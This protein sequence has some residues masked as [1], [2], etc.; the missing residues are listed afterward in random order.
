MESH[1]SSVNLPGSIQAVDALLQSG[2]KVNDTLSDGESALV[3]AVA[4]AHWEL[5]DLGDELLLGSLVGGD[6]LR[7]HGHGDGLLG[8]VIV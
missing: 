3:V 1:A 4:N 5:A 8:E 2:A 6:L 7:G